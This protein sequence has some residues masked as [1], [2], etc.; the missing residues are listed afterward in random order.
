MLTETNVLTGVKIAIE[1][2]EIE[3]THD[4]VACEKLTSLH[5]RLSIA[6]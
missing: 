1:I 5:R 3:K 2:I 4:Q 6:Y